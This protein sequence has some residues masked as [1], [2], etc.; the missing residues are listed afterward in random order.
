MPSAA[1][2]GLKDSRGAT[3][4]TNGSYGRCEMADAE[5]KDKR[6][7]K[8]SLDVKKDKKD[9]SDKKEKKHKDKKSKAPKAAEGSRSD[10]ADAVD[11]SASTAAALETAAR[12]EREVS[13]DHW[14]E[15]CEMEC[16]VPSTAETIGFCACI[17]HSSTYLL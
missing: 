5:K 1:A 17:I 7:S 11:T 6:K 16:F 9:K 8:K 2:A 12:K 10:A 15:N 13:T 4:F 3:L 14:L